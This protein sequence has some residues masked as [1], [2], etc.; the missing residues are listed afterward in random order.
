MFSYIV[1]RLVTLIPTLFG[2]SLFV[3]LMIH[4][5]PGDAAR[6][7]LGERASAEALA[8]LRQELGLD[9]P[10]YVQYWRFLADIF[11]GD[12]GRSIKSGERIS[13]EIAQHFPATIELAIMSMLFATTFGV[14]AGVLSA[15]HRYSLLDYLSMVGA[16][17]GISM[18]IFWLGLVLILLFSV[19]LHLLPISGRLSP[20]IF[21]P[22]TTNFYLLDSLLAGDWRAFRDVLLHLIL[23]A[24][25]LGT[26]PLA[27]IAR[28][29]RSSML[30]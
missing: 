25:T 9:A 8:A 14:L 21:F 6:V 19:K 2:I 5:T 15:T 18:P 20:D 27:I 23:P 26:I 17:V 1:K 12:L 22:I 4:L 24:I 10:W 3:F 28:M 13:V 16:L 29:T 7:M 30:E 11:Q